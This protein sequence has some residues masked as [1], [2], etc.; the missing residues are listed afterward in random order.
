MNKFRTLFILA[1]IFVM[2]PSTVEP[3]DK[4]IDAELEEFDF[5]NGLFSRGMYEMAIEGYKDFLKQYPRSE[6]AELASFR[7]AEC[8]F[9]D[10]KYDEAINR[11]SL[12]LD[13]YPDGEMAGKATLRKAQVHYRKGD[14]AAAKRILKQILS[15]GLDE[16][17]K[18]S[19]KYY[20]AGIHFK[21]GEHASS[22]ALLE[23][24]IASPAGGKY[25]AFAYINLGDI[26]SEK[27]AH[28]KAARYYEKAA[29]ETKEAEIAAKSSFR[30][31]NA[32]YK[33]GLFDKAKS[34]YSK[35]T[36]KP[37][38]SDSFDE[39]A[40]GLVSTLYKSGD[41]TAAVQAAEDALPKLKQDESKAQ[42]LFLKGNALFFADEYDRAETV[43]DETIRSY[44]G[45]EFALKSMLNRS[46]VLYRIGRYDECVEAVADYM[47]RTRENTD[48]ALYVK[49]EALIG[50][51]YT[52]QAIETYEEIAS[53]FPESVYHREAL[54][55]M[56]WAYASSGEPAEA[57]RN[58]RMFVEQY[59]D[60]SRSPAV[61][62]KAAQE[63]LDMQRY[64]QAETD[65]MKFLST[66]SENPLKENVLFQLG[67]VYLEKGDT[68]KALNI[69]QKFISEFPDSE[70]ADA[71]IYWMG[72]AYQEQ[73]DFDRALK[74][75]SRLEAD[76]E[77]GFYHEAV[78]SMAYSYFQMGQFDKAA[79]KY[80]ALISRE[81]ELVLPEG[82]Y[83][84]VAEYYMGRDE[85]KISLE[86]LDILTRRYPD[87]KSEGEIL[88]MYAENYAGLGE[89]DKAR[90]RFLG[91]I[92]KGAPSPYRERSYLGLGKA[93]SAAGEY[94]KAVEMLT[95]ALAS[96]E[97]NLTGA[98]ARYEIGNVKFKVMDFKEAAKQYMMVAILYDDRELCSKALFRAGE[99]F[100]KAGM[101]EKSA[102]AYQELIQRYPGTPIAGEA[103][104]MI[105]RVKNGSR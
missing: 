54:Y 42:I 36:S 33:A 48:E 68:A 60:D 29:G 12:F 99:A 86:V 75:Y 63:N 79:E 9:M 62:L 15:G 65:Y 11:F 73:Q 98:L 85:S 89:W 105:G 92:E 72:R 16:N 31:G 46:W 93:Y 87:M 34:Q 55:E 97:D 41:Y 35:V 52:S 59:P 61:L 103:K 84:W 58:Y 40:T 26:Y 5:A 57:V 30:A 104:E 4:R 6:Y 32:Y 10:E 100:E 37:G 47:S 74:A 102:E 43:Y 83:K 20:L 77:S 1:L 101:P 3:Q 70:A 91:A 96:R 13:N 69:Y 45:S 56:G 90:E 66:Y 38:V 23:E 76:T 50:A 80:Y 24:V 53:D 18:T 28:E 64:S 17:L 94:D 49:G 2:L 14:L 88:Y 81:K 78:E 8:Y 7:I 67:R 22:E 25:T 19:A 82:V 51:G 95:E 71:A 27:G 39:A 44:P 21:Q